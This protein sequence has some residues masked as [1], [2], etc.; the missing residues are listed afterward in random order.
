MAK[1]E[2]R[3]APEYDPDGRCDGCIEPG[4]DAAIEGRG[5]HVPCEIMDM[6]WSTTCCGNESVSLQ[7]ERVQGEG[8]GEE[9]EGRTALNRFFSGAFLRL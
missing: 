2:P 5:C 4:R 8:G 6:R 9:G 1:Y 7:L 3:L